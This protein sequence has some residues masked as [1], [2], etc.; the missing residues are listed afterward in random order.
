[1][2]HNADNY[3]AQ[4]PARSFGWRAAIK[5]LMLVAFK[6]PKSRPNWLKAY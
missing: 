3:I 2:P 5:A 4:A 1:M 6:R